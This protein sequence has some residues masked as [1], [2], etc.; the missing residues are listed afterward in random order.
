[1]RLLPPSNNFIFKALLVKNEILV[2]D[3]LNAFPEFQDD[4]KITEIEILNPELPKS[5]DTEK[6]SILD[7]RAKDK[8]GRIF[9][10]EMQGTP[11]PFF[12]ERL[13]FYWSK[14]YGTG[15]QKG[16]KYSGLPKVYSITF[17]NTNLFKNTEDFH[18]TFQLLD[19]K[20]GK[21]LLTEHLEMHILELAKVGSSVSNLQSSLESWAYFFK[22]V[23]N[24][25]E[26][27]LQELRSKN[28]MIEKAIDELEYLS[29]DEK[30]RQMYEEQL[31]AE[32]DYNSG[33]YAAFRDGKLEGELTKALETARKM[34]EEGFN[35][36]QIIRITGLSQTQ[37][38]ENGIL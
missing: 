5:T 19:K 35:P 1:M 18:T 22:E 3:I 21:I 11:H 31:K 10:I 9:L 26:D 7:I 25:K 16:M 8:K 24:L 38:M 23:H 13:L 36:E 33:I 17:L 14:V 30:T 2:I 28:P 20:T 6:A 34:R 29:Q 4:S 27:T 12:P 32:F 15:I 37:L